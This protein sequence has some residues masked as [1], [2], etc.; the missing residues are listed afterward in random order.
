MNNKIQDESEPPENEPDNELDELARC[1]MA[2]TIAGAN[3]LALTEKSEK[4]TKA[5]LSAMTL[6]DELLREN[7]RLCAASDQPPSV[8][9][10]AAKNSFDH[11]MQKLLGEERPVTQSVSNGESSP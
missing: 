3:I 7:S 5:L 1:K 9:L 4:F 11:E 8:R 6:V 10:F 2:L